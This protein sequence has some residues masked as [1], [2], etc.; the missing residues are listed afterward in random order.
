[1]ADPEPR[2][3]LEL[4]DAL[5]VEEVEVT[6]DLR[7]LEVYTMKGLLTLPVARPARRRER[8]R[9]LREGAVGE[10]ARPRGRHLPRPRRG[11]RAQGI[12]TVRVGYRK[13]NDLSRC[14][15][16]VAAAADLASRSGGRRF[17]TIGH[18]FGG[19]VAI[20]AGAILGR[21]L[22]RRCD[23]RHSGPRACAHGVSSARRR[24]SSFTERTTRSCH[25]RR[26]ESSR[27][28]PATVRWCCSRAPGTC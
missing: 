21:A 8:R 11:V 4:L 17:V 15:H 25:R 13:P 18:S 14:V 7:H 26:V 12:G 9:H 3:P 24:C 5:V 10:R 6:A 28:S 27:C 1:M 22:P 2:S 20:Q 16:D 23:T 19:A